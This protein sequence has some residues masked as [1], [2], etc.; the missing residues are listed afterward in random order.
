MVKGKGEKQMLKY[1]TGRSPSV[2]KAVLK[3]TLTAMVSAFVCAAVLAR[4][5]DEEALRMENIG[6]GILAAHV[7]SVFLGTWA[8][9]GR[10]GKDGVPA[11][12]LTAGC[13]YACLLLVNGL[14]FGGEFT[15]L[16]VT[17]L[18]VG[19]GTLGSILISC[20]GSRGAHRRRYKI[21]K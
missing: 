12:A 18:L 17:V 16:G 2:G 6:Y 5:V 3:G 15:G 19:I 14:F 4:L 10:A 20:R 9:I 1:Q 11:A 8:A 21:T 7:L 13:Y